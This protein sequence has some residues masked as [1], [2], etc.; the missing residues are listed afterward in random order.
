MTTASELFALQRTDL[1]FDSIVARLAGVED[2]LG[3]TEELTVARERLDQCQEEVREIQARKKEMDYQ[4]EAARVKAAEIESKLYGGTVKNP[5]ELEDFQA[6]LTSLRGQLGN[7][8]DALLEAMLELE[9]GEAVLKEAE[10]ALAK[11]ETSWKAEQ[12]TLRETQA[13]L[14]QEIAELEA[15]RLDQLE[16]MDQVALSLYGLLRERRQGT[17]V[18][19]V[20]RGL[21]QGCRIS[22]PMSILQQARAGVGLVQCVSCERILLVN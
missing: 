12:V 4:A 14:K 9:E 1:A 21:C 5:K 13:T 10:E 18:A 11:I 15:K 8:E 19:V 2:Q 3:E 6:D 20:E 22:L 16:G 17:A 7:R